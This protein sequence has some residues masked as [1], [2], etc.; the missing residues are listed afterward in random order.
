M[1]KFVVTAGIVSSLMAPVAF[2]KEKNNFK[3]APGCGTAKVVSGD[4]CSNVKVQFAFEGC[5]QAHP[6]QMAAKIVCDKTTITARLQ[7]GN[8]RFEAQF[9]KVDDGWGAVAW[10]PMGEVKRFEKVEKAE[11][12]E[13]KAVAFRPPRPAVRST[14][15]E[16][17]VERKAEANHEEKKPAPA[18]EPLAPAVSGSAL[19]NF[20]FGGFADLR[21]SN[22]SVKD[23]PSVSSGNP[24]SGFGVE[25]GAVY[26][27][28][29]KDKLSAVLDI[30]FRRGKDVDTNGAATQ[31]N[32]SSGSLIAFGVDKSQV[33][34]K[35][36]ATSWLAVDFGQFDTIF[37]VELND[38][39]DRVFG[40]TGLVYDQTLPVTH[41]GVMAEAT[42]GM[43][44]GKAF[45]ANPNNKGSYG[46]STTGD[47][48]TEYGA[49]IGITHDLFHAQ[50]GYMTRAIN[51]ANGDGN[52]TRTLTDLIVGTTWQGFALDVEYNILANANKNTL[53][54]ADPNDTETNGTGLLA[55][56][57]YK[58]NDSWMAGVRYEQLSDDP[59]SASWKS[60]TATGAAVHYRV[61]PELELRA[62]YT[63]YNFK[64]TSDVKWTESRSNIAT[65]ILF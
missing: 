57:S 52:G 33:Y 41:T 6:E 63:G 16:T 20:K 51:K 28:Y 59:S 49:A 36:Q 12:V 61:S 42:E 9:D 24:E 11:K 25:D 4:T 44:Y 27:N 17:K 26:V 10:K 37:G 31:P 30:A 13:K 64:N 7:E 50:A 8:E 53:T 60:A 1:Q 62:E 38:S 21:F 14:A 39:K 65:L 15:A 34:V 40:K 58:F 43:F 5:P 54:P 29:A 3:P 35:Y 19:A 45:A 46:T 22:F 48:K 55:L 18:P 2:A 32:Q 23:N 56:A 47:D